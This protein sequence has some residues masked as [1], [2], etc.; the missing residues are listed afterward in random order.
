MAGSRS[1]QDASVPRRRLTAASALSPAEEYTRRG[2]ARG[3]G[4]TNEAPSPARSSV[5]SAAVGNNPPQEPTTTGSRIAAHGACPINS[6]A[7]NSS[8]HEA[9]TSSGNRSAA[10][11]ACRNRRATADPAPDNRAFLR[12]CAAPSDPLPDNRAFLR[13][14]DAPYGDQDAE[15][16]GSNSRI[17]REAITTTTG[18][19]S[20]FFPTD[21][22]GGPT[23]TG[24]VGAHPLWNAHPP[25]GWASERETPE[26]GETVSPENAIK[27]EVTPTVDRPPNFP[28]DFRGGLTPTG[29]GISSPR[30]D[31]RP[32]SRARREWEEISETGDTQTPENAML[33]D[34]G[35]CKEQQL[36]PDTAESRTV[37]DELARKP[38]GGEVA[39]NPL[40]AEEESRE[41]GSRSVGRVGAGQKGWF[42][43]APRN[44]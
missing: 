8:P 38:G 7:G 1:T 20:P 41:E 21:F 6:A 30:W 3:G 29:L 32:L 44:S 23:P 13:F 43:G 26:T 9:T 14:C 17:K 28:T 12:F 34:R 19:R 27:R 40:A 25:S 39:G 37:K 4:G 18:D 36:P 33:V 16:G 11:G 22:R 35:D 15:E 24:L 2:C 10:N 31:A 5:K 42:W